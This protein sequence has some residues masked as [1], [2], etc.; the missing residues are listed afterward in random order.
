MIRSKR[1][2]LQDIG[3]IERDIKGVEKKI[4]NYDD[5]VDYEYYHN[6]KYWLWERH[7]ILKALD[8]LEIFLKYPQL[9]DDM[10]EEDSK[11]IKEWLESEKKIYTN[12]KI[13]DYEY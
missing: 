4:A 9:L 8:S 6:L 10:E 11:K 1:I 13:D 2:T 12:E 3:I 7:E 5:D